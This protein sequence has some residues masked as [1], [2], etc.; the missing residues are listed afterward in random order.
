MTNVTMKVNG[1]EI[2]GSPL[3]L[4]F[5]D[6]RNYTAAYVRLFEISDKWMKDLGLNIKLYDFGKG[7]T[8]IVFSLGP[9]D[10][11]ED[12]LN[13]VRNGNGRLEIRFVV[14][15]TETI[16]CLCYYQSQAILT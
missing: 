1:V 9:C 15:T 12:Y 5:G 7:Y 10:F 2:Y 3:S 11:Q 13:L 16:N 6:N 8:F 4:D 14:A